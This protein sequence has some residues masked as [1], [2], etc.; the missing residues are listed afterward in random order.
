MEKSN[1]NFLN[2]Q[3][4]DQ[5][6]FS[7]I[8]WE[9]SDSSV[10]LNPRSSLAERTSLEKIFKHVPHLASH[11]WIQS[12]G[13]TQNL[14]ESAKWTALSKEAFLVSAQA[15]NEHLGI[16]KSDRLGLAL[17]LFHVGGLSILARS[18]LSHAEVVCYNQDWNPQA[19]HDWLANER[20]S[21]LSLV[22]TQLFDLIQ[23]GLRCPPSLR[24]VVIGGAK[25]ETKLSQQAWVLGWPVLASFGM[26]EL[27]SQVATAKPNSSFSDELVLLDH[28]NAKVESDGFLQLQSSSLMSGFAQLKHESVHFEETKLVNGF[29]KCQDQA[30]LKTR[31]DLKTGAIETLLVIKGRPNDFVKIKG[32]GINLTHLRTRFFDWL[33]QKN[34]L[35]S[36]NQFAVLDLP[37]ERDGAEL[38]LVIEKSASVNGE[39][40]TQEWNKHSSGLEKM[41]YISIE[42]IPVSALGK[43]LYQKLRDLLQE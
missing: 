17:P 13:S 30:Q 38:C 22:P 10:L 11:M 29:W 16:N 20:I 41:R 19:F 21:I 9:S 43:I 2:K 39:W 42:Q 15:V 28:I 5:F 26:T 40:L 35:L 36:L 12:S 33:T 1:L 7:L 3:K 24:S 27:C 32:E 34:I 14:N 6:N 25:L 18:F 31:T 37:H 4:K 23:S 8:D